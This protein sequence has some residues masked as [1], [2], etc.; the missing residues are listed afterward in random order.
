MV[1]DRWFA[2]SFGGG[3]QKLEPGAIEHDFGLRVVINTVDHNKLR[4]ADVRTPDDNSTTTR[5]QA[6]RHSSQEV[7]EIDPERDLVRGLEGAPCDPGLR[8][9][10]IFGQR[11]KLKADRS[12]RT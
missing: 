11:D 8:R 5:T 9:V 1:E 4:S 7:F 3:Y 6:S 10:R 12:K 2:I